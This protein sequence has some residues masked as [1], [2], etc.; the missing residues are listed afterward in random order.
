MIRYYTS[1]SIESDDTLW[2]IAQEYNGD[3]STSH[4]INSIIN[5]NNMNSDTLYSGQNLIVYY[6][7]DIKE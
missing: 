6:S 7:S 1:I 5:M 4:Y 3:E 2:N